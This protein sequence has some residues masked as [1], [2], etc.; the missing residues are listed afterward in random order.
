MAG[1]KTIGRGSRLQSGI[2]HKRIVDG[3]SKPNGL[4]LR[5]AVIATYVTDDSNHPSS[6]D[7]KNVP[8]AV[9]CD[10]I[11]YPSVSGQRWHFLSKVLVSQKRGGL[12]DDSSWQPKAAT[13]NLVTGVLDDQL[14]SNPGQFDGDHVL[15]GFLNNSFDEPM[16]LRG[17]PHPS[18]DVGNENYSSGKRLKLKRLDGN[19]NWEKFKGVFYGIDDLG[20]HV[21][22]ST[23]AHDGDLSEGG[24]EPA[25]DT[26]GTSGNQSR[27]L[28]Q[29][30]KH[31]VVF[32]DMTNP[33]APVE[34]GKFSCSKDS[35]EILLTLLP[36]L[37]VEGK[38][39]TAKLTLGNGAVSATIAEHLESFWTNSVIPW[40]A[41]I[42]VPTGTGPSGVPIN[43]PPPSWN[44]AI[45]SGKLTFPDG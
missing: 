30:S 16:I 43:N 18:R 10:V 6:A 37:K 12:H 23:F 7:S 13:M 34:T 28:P 24:I 1:S 31:E 2:T 9:Y 35:F 27:H 44:S 14:G 5:G 25:P 8:L 40:L 22:D 3:V 45:N 32:Y 11:V 4:L 15:I 38:D 36:C 17:L 33:L 39:T 21:V 29:N 42:T 19:P 26:T 41:A 20:N